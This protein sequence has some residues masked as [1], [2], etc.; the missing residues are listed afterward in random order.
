MW[1]DLV[2]QKIKICEK[3]KKKTKKQKKKPTRTRTVPIEDLK[4][5]M[6]NEKV[7]RQLYQK[8]H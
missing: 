2:Q 4:K 5:E 8:I 7:T 1:L 6:Q 3:K